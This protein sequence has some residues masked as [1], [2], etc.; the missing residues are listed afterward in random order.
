MF[1]ALLALVANKS[2]AIVVLRL[3]VVNYA[4]RMIKLLAA[5]IARV[6]FF[7]LYFMVLL[8]MRLEGC[9]IGKRFIAFITR[10]QLLAFVY[11]FRVDIEGLLR[12][13]RF[14]AKFT[15]EFYTVYS[16]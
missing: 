7:R 14:I 10:E 11:Y 13:K 1:E 5:Y 8:H 2:P 16:N 9:R 15:M 6:A 12:Y 4:A 3:L